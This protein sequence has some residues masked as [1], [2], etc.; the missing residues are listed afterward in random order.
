MERDGKKCVICG[1][2]K[3]IPIIEKVLNQRIE[4]YQWYALTIDHIIPVCRGGL[5]NPENLRVLCKSCN[6]SKGKK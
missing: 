3:S 6:S 5:N 1:A 2:E 4:N